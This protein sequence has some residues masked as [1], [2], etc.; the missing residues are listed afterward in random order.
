[1]KPT[2]LCMLTLS[3][4]LSLAPAI[5]QAD[6]YSLFVRKDAA[7]GW[8]PV[9]TSATGYTFTPE[10]IAPTSLRLNVEKSASGA[11]GNPCPIVHLFARRA[12][13]RDGDWDEPLI[14][15]GTCNYQLDIDQN[16]VV[17]PATINI[18]TSPFGSN[19]DIDLDHRYVRLNKLSSLIITNTS[20]GNNS[21]ID[22]P[23][24]IDG[25]LVKLAQPGSNV[26]GMS[27]WVYPSNNAGPTPIWREYNFGSPALDLDI[28]LPNAILCNLSGPNVRSRTVQVYEHTGAPPFDSASVVSIYNTD[29]INQ[30]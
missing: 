12:S 16:N 29:C 28:K 6:E 1:M 23:A 26:T 21:T 30:I 5:S 24:F 18:S 25:S 7:T 22:Q 9:V 14:N 19:G 27:V 2:V 13:N 8:A 3:S 17:Q 20:G 10:L 11:N 15:S 4:V